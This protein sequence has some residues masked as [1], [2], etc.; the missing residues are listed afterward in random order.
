M[1][2]RYLIA[3][4]EHRYNQERFRLQVNLLFLIIADDGERLGAIVRSES[5]RETN[6]ALCYGVGT[7]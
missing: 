3:E 5:Y 4:D 7:L 1:V 6:I 2:V